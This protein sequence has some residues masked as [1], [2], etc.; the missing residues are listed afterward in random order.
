MKRNRGSLSNCKTRARTVDN[1]DKIVVL[2]CGRVVEQGA[3]ADLHAIE[4]GAY[5]RMLELQRQSSAWAV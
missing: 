5:R 1:A 2:D 4:G 3:P